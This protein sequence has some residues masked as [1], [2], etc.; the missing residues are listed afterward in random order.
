[1]KMIR[2]S[3]VTLKQ[4]DG[5]CSLS[6][7]EKIE[8]AKLLD[9]VGV[10]VIELV[11]IRNHK[12]DSLQIKSIAAVVSGSTLAVPVELSE[13]SVETTWNALQLAKRPRLQVCA[14]TSSVQMEYF[15]HKK[16]ESMLASLFMLCFP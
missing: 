2:I 6:F 10:S 5:V 3:D 13:E 4:A 12:I 7:K 8:I 11:G 16:P 15:L 1:M 14:P 9:K